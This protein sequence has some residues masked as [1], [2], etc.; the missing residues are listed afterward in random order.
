[1]KRIYCLLM[2]IIPVIAFSQ[3]LGIGVKAGLNFSN[4]TNASAINASSQSGFQAGVFL[5]LGHKLIG[6]RTEVLYSRQGYNY[7][8]DS[9]T[10][11]VKNDYI[12]LAQLLAINI[13]KFVQVQLGMQMGYLLNAKAD[14]STKT[15]NASI[16]KILGYYNRFD[17]GFAGGLE[18]HPVGG[19]LIGARYNISFSNL[20]KQYTSGSSNNGSP[21][22]GSTS[23]INF[24]NNIIQVF[25][26]YRF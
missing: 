25:V 9:T 23:G 13:T 18:V 10:G 15:G 11:S 3:K 19:L 4:I 21:S 1:M 5:G 24:K 14:S 17:Y 16:D 12:V 7:S 2:I 6:S 26:G 8:S 22:F 20:Y